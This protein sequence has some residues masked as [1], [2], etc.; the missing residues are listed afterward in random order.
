MAKLFASIGL[1]VAFVTLAYG[2][3]QSA[4]V[5]SAPS[6][7]GP[8]VIEPIIDWGKCPQLAP[9]ELQRKQ[10]TEIIKAC[11]EANPLTTAPDQLNAEAVE[12]HRIKL[13]ECALNKED[14]FNADKTYKY[15][16]AEEELKKKDVEAGIKTKILEQ[17][18]QCKTQALEKFPAAA[19][20]IEQVQFYQS[21]MDFHVSQLC[22]IKIMLPQQQ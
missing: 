21:C 14:W 11:L 6:A 10:K 4:P 13:G 1:V 19:A 7:S 18:Q 2:A 5:S 20:V 3:P 12:K 22:N 9:T 15:A 16:K 17:H 8:P